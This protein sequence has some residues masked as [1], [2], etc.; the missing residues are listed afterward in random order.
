MFFSRDDYEEAQIVLSTLAHF[1]G[2]HLLAC[3]VWGEKE[4]KGKE[5]RPDESFCCNQWA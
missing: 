2:V 4:R 3:F 5:R 1:I